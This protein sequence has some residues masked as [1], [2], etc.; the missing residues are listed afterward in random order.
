M[1]FVKMGA[2]RWRAALLCCAFVGLVFGVGLSGAARI[3]VPGVIA[4]SGCRTSAVMSTDEFTT[5]GFSQVRT[6]GPGA[7]APAGAWVLVDDAIPSTSVIGSTNCPIGGV[8][9]WGTFVVALK[10]TPT[11]ASWEEADIQELK[12]IQDMNC[13]GLFEDGLDITMQV[14]TGEELRRERSVTFFNGPQSPV[15][16]LTSAGGGPAAC[17]SSAI[18]LMVVVEIGP[19]P[20]SGSSFGLMLEA[21]AAEVPGLGIISSGFSS[22][23]NPAGSSIR[24]NIIGGGGGGG[25]GG[26]A[27]SPPSGGGSALSSFDTNGNGFLDDAEFFNVIDAW[28]SQRLDDQTFFEAVDKWAQHELLSVE[29]AGQPAQ[30]LS[31]Q[32]VAIE[33]RAFG[34]MTFAAHGQA[35]ARTSVEVYDLGGSKIFARKA[36][37][38]NVRWE[39]STLGGE[40]AANGVYLYRV[41]VQDR[42]GNVVSSEVEKLVILR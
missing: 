23:R 14:R 42:N 40:L 10:M 11:I 27:P 26:P 39:L 35:I 21:L 20:V 22:S 18:A 1:N 3:N 12:L 41:S 19:N 13:N 36:P 9:A 5:T 33:T 34:G 24:L 28:A 38:R 32:R 7:E 29:S 16:T 8:D 31:L 17:G 25:G 2:G 4:A 6:V 30:A 37:G 15:F